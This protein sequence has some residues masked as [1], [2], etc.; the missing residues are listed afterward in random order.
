MSSNHPKIRLYVNAP[1]HAGVQVTIAEA[2]YHYLRHVMR[3]PAGTLLALFNGKDGEWLAELQEA[4][5]KQGMA[6]VRGQRRLQKTMPD[7]WLVFAPIK[8]GRIDFLV[9]KA[10]ELGAMR[11]LPV[12]TDRT[13]VN[14]VNTERL[15]A[16]AVEAAEQSERLEV[17]EVT[18]P[19]TLRLLLQDWPQDRLL[20][21]GDE[22][23]NGA[24]PQEFFA[25]SSPAKAAVLVGPEGGFTAQEFALLRQYVFAKPLSL[26][27]RVLRA[28]TAALAALTCLQAH[29]GDWQEKPRFD[30]GAA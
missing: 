7:H 29:W 5:K 23:G 26:G 20:I 10:T 22:S 14:R 8:H 1:L 25:T 24:S 13:I 3:A 2:Q 15:Y 21:Y 6:L 16:N 11:L 30:A 9:E 12:I 4:G 19:V 18:E 17:P 27:P 28:D